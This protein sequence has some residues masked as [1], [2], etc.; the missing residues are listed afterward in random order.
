M[1]AGRESGESSEK[2][3]PF[4]LYLLGKIYQAK[5]ELDQAYI[6][7]RESLRIAKEVGAREL[8]ARNYLL[9]GRMDY[10]LGMHDR[11]REQ[12]KWALALTRELGLK[13][14]AAECRRAL[15]DICY[16]GESDY[17]KA[18]QFYE[19][20]TEIHEELNNKRGVAQLKQVMASLAESEGEFDTAYR[21]IKEACSL[22]E[23]LEFKPLQEEYQKDLRRIEEKYLGKE[24][25]VL[26]GSSPAWAQRQQR[27]NAPSL[28]WHIT[29]LSVTGP[30]HEHNEDALFYTPALR[31]AQGRSSALC[32]ICDGL[33]GH[34]GGE[35][36]SQLA[37]E[38]ISRFLEPFL[39][40]D[41]L[42]PESRRQHLGEALAQANTAIYR[43][44]ED[45]EPALPVPSPVEG[46]KVEG[47]VLRAVEGTDFAWR[48]GMTVVAAWLYDDTVVAAHVG[49]SRLYTW[50][51]QLTQIT[52]DHTALE[53]DLRRRLI[54][55]EQA[56]ASRYRGGEALTQALSIRAE[57]SPDFHTLTVD[58]ELT[59]LLCSDGLHKALA[60]EDMATVLKQEQDLASTTRQMVDLARERGAEDDITLI[61][62]RGTIRHTAR[63]SE[64]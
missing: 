6:H 13:R 60:A 57:V 47:L 19:E 18:W 58:R 45:R 48:I 64:E 41:D 63:H 3:V 55:R 31:T 53:L 37:V 49:D 39:T 5:G 61:L 16:Y 46:D 1:G 52:T 56:Q 29:G 10:E 23:G 14:L 20:S 43:R 44:N 59:L 38:E 4:N 27:G 25:T 15:G 32:L 30:G 62:V 9:M 28:E 21:L 11:A 17:E 42:D 36:A 24:D 33:G 51:G 7:Y 8:A 22:L 40:R 26:L 54:T 2:R 34:E 35:V 12:I 50:D